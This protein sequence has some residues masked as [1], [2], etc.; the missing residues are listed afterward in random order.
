MRYSSTATIK[1]NI[2]ITVKYGLNSLTIEAASVAEIAANDNIR[3]VL[4][5]GE[6]VRFLKNGVEI[7]STSP[8]MS[9]DTIIVEK[10]ANAK[11]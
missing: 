3:A 9:G 2:M 8:L 10:Q 7:S 11:A 1:E 4:G 6:N 5:F